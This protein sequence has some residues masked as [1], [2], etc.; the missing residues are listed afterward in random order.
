G[1]IY[2]GA[3]IQTGGSKGG[4]NAMAHIHAYPDDLD[5]V[6]AYVAPVTT[7]LPDTRWTGYLDQIGI[8]SCTQMLRD[9]A[10]EMLVRRNAL[11]PLVAHSQSYSFSKATLD[12]AYETAVVELVFAFWMTRGEADCPAVPATTATD[13]ALA[14]FLDATNPPI[15]YSDQ[16]YAVLIQQFTYQMQA[17]LGYPVWEHANLDDLMRF[18]YEDWSVYMPEGTAPTFTPTQPR[19]LTSYLAS[20]ATHV[21]HIGGEWDP[22]G[23]GYP[24]IAGTDAFDYRVSHGSHWSSGIY[25]L[26]PADHDAALATLKRWAR[27]AMTKSAIRRAPVPQLDPDVATLPALGSHL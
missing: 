8:A 3:K 4:E 20:N 10:R 12:H 24:T 18:S 14:A 23:G 22:W 11:E 19:A 9:L 5:G 27:V 15:G 1:T 2:T 7:D 6:V 26:A 17:E 13:S 25:S 16:L 21:M